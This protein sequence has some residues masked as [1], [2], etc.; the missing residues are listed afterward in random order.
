MDC[1]HL[2]RVRVRDLDG[3]PRIHVVVVLGASSAAK[4]SEKL[5]EPND[6]QTLRMVRGVEIR[7]CILTGV[8]CGGSTERS[9]R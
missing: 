2:V 6:R 7:C 9:I 5:N 4:Y 1:L 8:W 3:T